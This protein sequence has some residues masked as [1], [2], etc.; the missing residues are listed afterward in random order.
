MKQTIAVTL[1]FIVLLAL[2]S[3]W[4]AGDRSK[5]ASTA[6]FGGMALPEAFGVVDAQR[7]GSVAQVIEKMPRAPLAPEIVS[8]T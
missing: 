4:I 1:V 3:I 8:A 5:N 6:H 2:M 7:G